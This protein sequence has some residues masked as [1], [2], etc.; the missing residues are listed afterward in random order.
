VRV[1][2][3]MRKVKHGDPNDF[4]IFSNQSV[5]E[6]LNAL[7]IIIGGAAGAICLIALLVGGIGVMNIMLISVMERT[8]EIGVR[9]A[10]GARP[11]TIL[12]QFI[13]EAVV[14]SVMGGA[15]GVILAMGAVTAA[16]VS[17]DLPTK[18]PLYA[19]ALA[20]GSSAATGL[21]AGIY[22]AARAARLDPIEALRYE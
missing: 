6:R 16:G 4:E 13:T 19:I 22:P 10:L 20:L 5:A 1:I 7:A 15:V 3:E 18:V 2:R 9:K 21:F 17:L 8:R 14:L 12:G 11:A